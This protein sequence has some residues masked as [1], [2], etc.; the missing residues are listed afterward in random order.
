MFFMEDIY[1]KKQ[2][3][4]LTTGCEPMLPSIIADV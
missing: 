2:E 4:E 1:T 3:K